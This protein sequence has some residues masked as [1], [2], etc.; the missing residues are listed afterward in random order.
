MLKVLKTEILPVT[1]LA[2]QLWPIKLA[3][4]ERL[5]NKRFMNVQEQPRKYFSWYRFSIFYIVICYIF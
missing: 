2:S 1:W 3:A 5:K 4:E